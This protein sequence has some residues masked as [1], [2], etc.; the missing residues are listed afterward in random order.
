MEAIR[1][2]NGGRLSYYSFAYELLL[3]FQVLLVVMSVECTHQAMVVTICLVVAMY[4]IVSSFS[5]VHCVV[6]SFFHLDDVSCF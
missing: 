5:F 4:E 2:R 6:I 1:L 3:I